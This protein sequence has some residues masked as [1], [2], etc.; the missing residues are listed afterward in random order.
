MH[1]LYATLGT[2]HMTRHLFQ[3]L[4]YIMVFKLRCK[5]AKWQS[6]NW[7]KEYCLSS[8]LTN[9]YNLSLIKNSS[10]EFILIFFECLYLTISNGILSVLLALPNQPCLFDAILQTQFL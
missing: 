10:K 2:L 6:I 8:I 1:H 7:K 3:L 9:G 4:T 5:T